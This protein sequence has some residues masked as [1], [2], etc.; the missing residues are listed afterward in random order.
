MKIKII[1]A[2]DQ[3]ENKSLDIAFDV[4]GKSLDYSSYCMTKPG[5]EVWQAAW[6]KRA[7]PFKRE[8]MELESWERERWDQPLRFLC[9][10]PHA[11][12]PSGPTHGAIIP[13][14]GP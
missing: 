5:K 11:P 14:E 13:Y 12:F 1:K 6:S 4:S 7:G 10:F 3:L 9:R 2:K 8:L